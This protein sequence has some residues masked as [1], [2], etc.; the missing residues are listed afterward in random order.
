MLE[1]TLFTMP[2]LYQRTFL[3]DLE[4]C[5][6][7]PVTTRTWGNVRWG[8]GIAVLPY[9]GWL[10]GVSGLGL[11]NIFDIVCFLLLMGFNVFLGK[12]QPEFRAN[13]DFL[14]HSWV[15]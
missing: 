11:G 14:Y 10:P 15:N 3:S 9:V 4:T 13:R 7:N 5:R 2:G 12:Y 1:A 8:E 6:S